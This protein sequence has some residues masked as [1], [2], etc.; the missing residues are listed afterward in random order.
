[1]PLYYKIFWQDIPYKNGGCFPP[2]AIE[3]DTNYQF[4]Y[5]NSVTF[6]V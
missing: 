1:M 5:L 2:T 3:P 4:K 6:L